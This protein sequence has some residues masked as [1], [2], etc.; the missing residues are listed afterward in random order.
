[1]PKDPFPAAGTADS[2][3]WRVRAACRGAELSVFFSPDGERRG[4]RDRREARA[5]QICQ[6]CPVLVR[7]RDH[8]LTAGESY[9]VWGG[10]TESDRRKH[11][12]RSRRG[13]RR[14][15]GSFHERPVGAASGVRGAAFTGSLD[16]AYTGGASRGRLTAG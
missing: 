16:R 12:H 10:M 6:A 1:M 8:A 15:L 7:C 4:A 3:E 2:G 14:P 13:E 11:T 9:G 5:R